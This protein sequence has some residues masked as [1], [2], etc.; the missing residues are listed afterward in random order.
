MKQVIEEYGIAL[1][2]MIVGISFIQQ[3]QWVMDYILGGIG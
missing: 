2:L 1:V 3:M